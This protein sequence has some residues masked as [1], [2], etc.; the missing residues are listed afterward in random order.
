MIN[1]DVPA[2]MENKRYREEQ[3]AI[4]DVVNPE[5]GFVYQTNANSNLNGSC[6]GALSAR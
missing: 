4:G 2:F 6:S 1:H 5:P 3:R